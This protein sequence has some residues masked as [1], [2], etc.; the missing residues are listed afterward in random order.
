[1]ISSPLVGV[2]DF[3]E[4]AG[5]ANVAGAAQHEKEQQSVGVGLLRL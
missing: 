5:A 2:H 3:G 1:M 4:D